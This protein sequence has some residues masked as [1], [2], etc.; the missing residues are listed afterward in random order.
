MYDSLYLIFS[1]TP[2]FAIDDVERG[3]SKMAFTNLSSAQIGIIVNTVYGYS[4]L[5]D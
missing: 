4:F 1:F 3:L 5:N 2:E